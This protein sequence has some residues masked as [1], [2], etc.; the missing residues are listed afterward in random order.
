MD[1]IY[2]TFIV[3]IF[4]LYSMDELFSIELEVDMDDIVEFDKEYI[5]PNITIQPS[6]L[7]G[8]GIFA[9][10]P[11]KRGDIIE[12]CPCVRV[13]NNMTRGR[14]GDYTFQYDD[15]TSL[16]VFGYGSIY[17]HK[18]T[19]NAYYSIVNKCQMEIVA[20]EDIHIGEEICISYGDEYFANR[21]HIEE[22][23]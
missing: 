9:I 19:P 3:V 6:L 10:Q 5:V 11:Y 1:F 14:I 2:L 4:I 13:N 18:S 16:V 15:T 8:R 22:K 21:Y 20:K 7:G 12:I 17:N 23:I